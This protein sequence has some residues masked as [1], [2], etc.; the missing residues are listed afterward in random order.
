[1]TQCHQVCR[2]IAERPEE[3]FR[4]RSGLLLAG[5]PAVSHQPG[6]GFDGAK[7]DGWGMQAGWS[8]GGT[9]K[10]WLACK[11]M[12]WMDAFGKVVPGAQAINLVMPPA[13]YKWNGIINPIVLGGDLSLLVGY[14]QPKS[15]AT[16]VF[17]GKM[18]FSNPPSI[19]WSSN[20]SSTGF[21]KPWWWQ[22]AAGR[23]S[24][25]DH[26]GWPWLHGAAQRDPLAEPTGAKGVES[27]ILNFVIVYLF[28]LFVYNVSSFFSP[29]FFQKN[30]IYW[31]CPEPFQCQVVEFL[32]ENGS[33]QGIRDKLG[34]TAGA[35]A[36]LR[37]R[38][39]LAALW[40]LC[41]W[42][43]G[44][45]GSF[46]HYCTKLIISQKWLHNIEQFIP[47]LT[48]H[49]GKG[50]KSGQILG[51]TQDMWFPCTQM[52]PQWSSAGEKGGVTSDDSLTQKSWNIEAAQRWQDD[53][54]PLG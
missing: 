13:I 31:H 46:A 3:G 52:I 38:Q 48:N 16:T 32:L 23:Q 14:L 30:A 49:Y 54:W 39:G 25:P 1:M 11:F 17:L 20:R 5:P 6:S 44:W 43:Q 2:S 36:S 21:S 47:S 22:G 37:H 7:F 27:W 12:A 19:K 15:S 26:P 24:G 9:T 34:N 53:I 4:Y 18:T 10:S 41:R 8:A 35:I 50:I 45:Y 51:A 42:S 33:S 29:S 28:V 40:S